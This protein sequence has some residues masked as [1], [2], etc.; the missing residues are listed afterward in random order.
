MNSAE[1]EPTH[2]V[3]T[4]QMALAAQ[5]V[6]CHCHLL[7]LCCGHATLAL[8]LSLQLWIEQHEDSS[9]STRCRKYAINKPGHYP[10]L[11]AVA[12]DADEAICGRE[13]HMLHMMV[14]GGQA[15]QVHA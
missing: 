11:Q 9:S 4:S 7:P 13:I 15:A 6:T 8:M 1:F 5:L 10:E 2:Y 14:R 3:A 12:D